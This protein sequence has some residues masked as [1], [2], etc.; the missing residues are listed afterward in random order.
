[1][2]T[3]LSICFK[4]VSIPSSRGAESA[5][6]GPHSGEPAALWPGP[7]RPSTEGQ[8]LHPPAWP[9]F[10]SGSISLSTSKRFS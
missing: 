2:N 3:G 9:A 6:C 10:L 7:L 1:M 5:V 4:P 8:R